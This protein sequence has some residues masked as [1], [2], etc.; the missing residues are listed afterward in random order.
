MSV[1]IFVE[2]E[3]E[4]DDDDDDDDNVDDD[5]DDD[6]DDGDDGDDDDD[7]ARAGP[8]VVDDETIRMIV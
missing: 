7:G 2:N 8:F 3:Y 4:C 6:D 5:D 1:T